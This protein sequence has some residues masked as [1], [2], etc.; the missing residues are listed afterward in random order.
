MLTRAHFDTGGVLLSTG[1][2]NIEMVTESLFPTETAHGRVDLVVRAF[3][4]QRQTLMHLV[5]KMGVLGRVVAFTWH[6]PGYAY[7][8]PTPFSFARN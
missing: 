4:V 6:A 7:G 8:R 1:N 5:V 3:E 2:P